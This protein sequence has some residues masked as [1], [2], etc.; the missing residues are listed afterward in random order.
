MTGSPS[1]NE[2]PYHAPQSVDEPN[3]KISFHFYR[4]WLVILPILWLYVLEYSGI[5]SDDVSLSPPLALALTWGTM[6][7]SCILGYAVRRWWILLTIPIYALFI[8]YIVVLWN[9]NVR[10]F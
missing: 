3:R 4:G 8:L 6:L 5:G 7:A 2:N 10:S 9:W 1:K